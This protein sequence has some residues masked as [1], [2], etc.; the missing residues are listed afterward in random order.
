MAGSTP[1]VTP[2]VVTNANPPPPITPTP[3]VQ[4]G[5]NYSTP[6]N[7]TPPAPA[8]AVNQAAPG[9]VTPPVTTPA[10]PAGSADPTSANYNP[11][12]NYNIPAPPGS[13]T[14]VA[15]ATTE[16]T[17]GQVYG[18]TGDPALDAALQSQED[19]AKSAAD[20]PDPN[21]PAVQA[22]IRATTLQGFQQEIDDTNASYSRELS[23]AVAAGQAKIGTNIAGE[24][25]SGEMGSTFG[26]AADN[27]VVTSNLNDENTITD[28]QRTAVDAIMDKSNTAA[29]AAIT[30]A[31]TAKSAG[32]DAYVTYLQGAQTRNATNATAAATAV[33]QAG[34]DPSTMTPAQMAQYLKNYGISQ[35][36]FDKAYGPAKAAAAAAAASAEKTVAPGDVVLGADGK[37][38]YTAPAK[39]AADPSSV[40]EFEYA[41]KNSGYTGSYTDFLKYQANL[42]PTAPTAADNAAAAKAQLATDT[43]TIEN[44]IKNKIATS[45]GANGGAR[46]DQ[47]LSPSE[48]STYKQAWVSGGQSAADFDAEF[49]GYKNPDPTQKYD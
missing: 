22:Q 49:G 44:S 33:V 8:P 14:Y 32:V 36:D 40:Q 2:A 23:S 1:V 46:T 17:A 26:A 4:Y 41:V 16:P 6:S 5:A 31:K 37:P 15:P 20:A 18:E 42:K 10:A 19:A 11:A 25:R 3:A 48:W 43:A 28:N 35:A 47:Y 27:N 39:P 29:D 30:A 38:V 45:G 12:L 34:L 9:T 7:A 21:D 24:A 13:P